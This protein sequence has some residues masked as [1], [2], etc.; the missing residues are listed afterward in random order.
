MRM[1]GG[2]GL[3]MNIVHTIVTDLLGGEISVASDYGLG[4]QV[5]LK[6]P[7]QS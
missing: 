4:T 6:L 2:S 1:G 3:G 5:S 7:L